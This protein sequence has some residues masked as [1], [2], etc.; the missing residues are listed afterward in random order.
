MK[1]CRSPAYAYQPP[2][3]ANDDTSWAGESYPVAALVC[4]I[5]FFMR[6]ILSGPVLNTMG[7]NYGDED[8]SA[9]VK[10]HPGTWFMLASFPLL[11]F[12]R[13][14][15]LDQLLRVA[16]QHTAFFSFIVIYAIIF[17]YWAIRG[18]KG[19]GLILDVHIVMPICAV[20]FSYAP[21]SCLR[22]IVKLYLGLAVLNSLV[23]IGEALTH[24]RIFTFDPDWEVL[25]QDYFRSSAFL[26]H[27]LTNASFTAVATLV[28]L[29]LRMQ[30]M[31]KAGL[32]LIMLSSLVAFGGR[33]SLG[34]SLGGFV[35]LGILSLGRFFRRGQLSVQQMFLVV[36]GV[37]LT[38]LVCGALL[39]GALHSDMGERLMNY[40][41]LNDDSASVRLL[42]FRVF[43]YMSPDDLLFGVDGDRITAIGLHT[44]VANPMSDIENP[45]VLMFMFL[46]A[47]MFALWLCG[48]AATVWRLMAGADV[49]LKLAVIEYF[50][51]SSTSNSFG[52]K[53]PVY[54][55]LAGIVVCVKRLELLDAP[56]WNQPNRRLIQIPS[57]R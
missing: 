42:S 33:S 23:G 5:G 17:V 40:S 37:I 20:V 44:G 32:F 3:A 48:W 45:W 38:P 54:A 28:M 22:A 55:I 35:I 36:L 4:A 31:L 7:I 46:G 6:I 9:F 25:H 56:Q 52:R 51:I 49:A 41:S 16:R 12:S 39:Y 15:P 50:L 1:L 8:A 11:L 21:K 43:G 30:R 14:N 24:K 27:P 34:V 13:G 26:G 47:I 53:D 10:I 18:P 2:V 19:I 29:S 57:K